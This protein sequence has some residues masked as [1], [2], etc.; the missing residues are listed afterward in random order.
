MGS[1]NK[2]MVI[3][4]LGR[5][6]E[7]IYSQ[8]TLAIAKF[9]LATNEIWSD[10]NSGEKHERTEWHRITAF[11]KLAE[12]CGLHLDKGRQVY[13]EGSLRTSNYEKDGITRYSTEVVASKVTFLGR[14]DQSAGSSIQN[15]PD[16]HNVYDPAKNYGVNQHSF[17]GGGSYQQPAV[18][19]E[20]VPDDDIP[21]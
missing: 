13:V 3:G 2:V 9:T 4:R 17:E 20:Q 6:P 8:D 16:Q 18:N 7:I 14:R 1:L 15:S 21:F 5:D 10:R 19:Q 11:G 12:I